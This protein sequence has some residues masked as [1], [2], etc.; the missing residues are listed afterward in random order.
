MKIIENNF[1]DC[2]FMW[3]F[4]MRVDKNLTLETVELN[5]NDPNQRTCYFPS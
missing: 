3:M 4:K 5:D 2:Y 1:I